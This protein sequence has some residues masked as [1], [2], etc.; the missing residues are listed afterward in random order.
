MGVGVATSQP[1]GIP[2][3]DQL[4]VGYKGWERLACFWLNE[5]SRH[6]Q[7]GMESVRVRSGAALRTGTSEWESLQRLFLVFSPS[8]T[9]GQQPFDLNLEL[10]GQNLTSQEPK[11]HLIQTFE[12]GH[13]SFSPVFLPEDFKQ[14]HLWGWGE[15]FCLNLL[16]HPVVS[17]SIPFSFS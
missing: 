17:P 13:L 11:D 16:F 7:M 4:V 10:S 9:K 15:G 14:S 12:R 3:L 6:L 8:L 1:K 2:S 5:I